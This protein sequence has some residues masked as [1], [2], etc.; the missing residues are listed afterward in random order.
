MLTDKEKAKLKKVKINGGKDRTSKRTKIL[1]TVDT[2]L[3][4]DNINDVINTLSADRENIEQLI[5]IYIT[6][7]GGITFTT[8]DEQL[9]SM[10]I[11]MLE[12]AKSLI[13]NEM[14]GVN[15]EGEDEENSD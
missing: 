6:R 4:K 2:Y 5:C 14:N 10:S 13:L 9:A 3:T 11:Y 1:N 12:R 8:D 15:K 7:E